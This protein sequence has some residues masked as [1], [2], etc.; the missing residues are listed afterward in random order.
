MILELG[1]MHFHG[2]PMPETPRG[3]AIEGTKTRLGP[4]CRPLGELITANCADSQ[5]TWSYAL[6]ERNFQVSQ[7]LVLILL[8][9]RKHGYFRKILAFKVCAMCL[10]FL[11]SKWVHYNIVFIVI[12]VEF[13]GSILRTPH[14]DQN[15]DQPNNWAPI[16]IL[17]RKYECFAI[18]SDIRVK[19]KV[20]K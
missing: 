13:A 14:I 11:R 12:I 16:F 20:V 1:L 3:A 18:S 9:R 2:K 10:G 4:V 6:W 7:T 15:G 17:P 8:L 19:W 5:V